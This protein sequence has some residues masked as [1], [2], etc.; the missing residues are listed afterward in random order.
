MTFLHWGCQNDEIIFNTSKSGSRLTLRDILLQL[1]LGVSLQRSYLH[2][3]LERRRHTAPALLFRRTDLFQAV[4]P[5]NPEHIASVT[6]V[7]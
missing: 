1:I 5:N 4:D 7:Q 6:T 2:M 3:I